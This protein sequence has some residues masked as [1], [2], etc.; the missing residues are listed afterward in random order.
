M[1]VEKKTF[2]GAWSSTF[3]FH[4]CFLRNLL[5]AVLYPKEKKPRRKRKAE[6][7]GNK[8]W[9]RDEKGEG[10]FLDNNCALILRIICPY[11]SRKIEN[12][13]KGCVQMEELEL[14]ECFILKSVRYIQ[15]DFT[16]L[17]QSLGMG[18]KLV[19]LTLGRKTCYSRKE[20]Y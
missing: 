20:M 19:I 12:S 15:R 8:W 16:F 18:G 4:V 11:L 2:L 5:E 7:S 14:I 1:K 9:E 6:D 3:A 13:R 10:K 17:L